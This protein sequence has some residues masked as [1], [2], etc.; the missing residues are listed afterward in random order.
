MRLHSLTLQAF[1]PFAGTHTIDFD[2]LSADKL[3]LLQ[4]PT[5]A[6]KTSVFDGICFALYGLPSGDRDLK[7]RSDH[8]APSLLTQ[9]VLDVTLG[10]HRLEITRIPQQERPKKRGRGTTTEKPKTILRQYGCDPHTGE[11]S[12]QPLSSTHQ[13]A[14]TEIIRLL[15]MS[16]E[17]F[18]Q[19]VMLPQNAFTQFLKADAVH[20]RNILSKLFH[21]DQFAA[22]ERWLHERQRAAER[23]LNEAR[24]DVAKL[25][26]RAHQAAGDLTPT[27]E[28]PTAD[29]PHT[30]NNAATWA[31]DLTQ[32]AK[33]HHHKA[34]TQVQEAAAALET[35]RTH[36]AAARTL[37]QQQ[38][39]HRAAQEGLKQL[40]QQAP[41]QQELKNRLALA[42]RAQTLAPLLHAAT[43]AT[44]AHDKA[45]THE[46][47]ARAALNAGHAVLSAVQLAA[48]EGE[49]RDQA[50]VTQALIPQEETLRTLVRETEHLEAER[51]QFAE[52][53]DEARSWLE[54]EPSHRAALTGRL[55]AA[56]QAEESCRSHQTQLEDIAGRKDAAELRDKHL[57]QIDRAEKRLATAQ[58]ATQEA[59]TS[60]IDIRRRRTDGMAAELAAD[61]TTGTPCP[62]CG[63]CDHPAPAA[64]HPDQPNRE[65]EEA[66]DKKHRKAQKAEQ[67]LQGK[68]QNLREQAAAASGAAGETPLADLKTQHEAIGK[69]L[70]EALAQAADFGPATEELTALERQQ[71]QMAD[72]DAV[73]S[74]KL[75]ALETTYDANHKRIEELTAQLTT[76]RQ[77]AP[78]LAACIADLTHTADTLNTAH[79]AA[80]DTA[81]TASERDRSLTEA[82]Q[83]AQESSFDT[84]EAATHALLTDDELAAIEAEI[85]TWREQRA[86]HTAVVDDPELAHAA[87][88]PPADL[89]QAQATRADAEHQHTDAAS[90]AAASQ[91]RH[92]ALADLTAQLDHHVTHLSPR[93]AA[94]ETVHHLHELVRGTSASNTLRMELEA[95]VLAARL[96][97]VVNAANTRLL[98]MSD[99]RYTLSH[100]DRREGGS[101]RSGLGLQIT[102]AWTGI[103]RPT[104]TLSGGESFYASLSLALGLADVVTHEAGGRMLDTLF[105]DEGFG[106]L[107]EDTLHQVLDVLD[108][109]RTHNRTVGLISHITEL[110]RRIPRRLN[111]NKT[112]S[113]S[114][115]SL[116]TQHAP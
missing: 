51:T 55:E 15:G 13:E 88:R 112:T 8:A 10:G 79:T 81:R 29:E 76:A 62:V 96:E 3:F 12:W 53:Q 63:A 52:Q 80:T 72:A 44:T 11:E 73:A 84:L 86:T 93:Q 106:N 101:K 100:T 97:E 46:A 77:G 23:E 60:Y 34:D 65:D 40:D 82:A 42:R 68:L 35:Q 115:L 116:I 39:T 32:Q 113:G 69:Q 41:H 61:L 4:G 74:R 102:D 91:A 99:H 89:E 47:T 50:A 22:I 24:N 1:G 71:T 64:P 30:L 54:Q 103:S 78:T 37:H 19:V 20:R 90:A 43:T 104:D 105:I 57:T 87:A 59:Y 45:K 14:A 111:V 18:C 75:T 98:R 48:A 114:T 6:G 27:T 36:E 33:D 38:A 17:Q 49:L 85:T 70:D 21:T 16:R 58:T 95:Y 9:V 108:S 26:E 66:A 28:A 7:L 83:A 67:T 94:Y 5:G 107:D 56:R 2:S 25:I 92:T 31:Q 110:R 109:L